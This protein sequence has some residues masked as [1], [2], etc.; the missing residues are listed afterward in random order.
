VNLEIEL[1]LVLV[2]AL[3]WVDL[4]IILRTLSNK[5]ELALSAERRR[6]ELVE[7]SR[8]FDVNTD[9]DKKKVKRLF[10]NY[11]TLKQSIDL[12]EPERQRILKSAKS[13]RKEPG[14]ARRIKFKNRYIRMD[15]SLDLALIASDTAR[16]T[17][18]AALLREK[19]FPVKLF[20]ANALADIMDPRSLPA[21]AESLLGAHRWYRDKVNML[22][23][24]YGLL[25]SEYLISI[26]DREENEIVE[27]LIDVAGLCVC[28]HLKS[29]LIR[30]LESGG[31][32][33]D[34]I[35]SAVRNAPD[36]SCAYCVHG[37][38]ITEDFKRDC[39]YQGKVDPGFKCRRWKL[40]VT[41]L[42]PAGNH[43][44]LMVKAA[45]NCAK[46]YAPS[47]HVPE[48]LDNPDKDIRSIAVKSLGQ[49]NSERHVKGL[50]HYLDIEET[51]LAAKLGLSQIL[52]THPRLS[53]LV[54]DVFEE[55]ENKR[56]KQA[57]SEILAG[58]IEYYIVKLATK[59]RESS[60]RLIRAVIQ[61]GKVSEIIE[62]LK[63]NKDVDLE[64][65]V[66]AIVKDETRAN[67]KLK[68]ECGLYLPESILS[69]I[70]L[71]KII[72]P[73]K[74]R[75]EARDG[76]M[77]AALYFILAFTL[78][79]FPF[80]YVIRYSD[81]V[82][83]V[84]IVQQLKTFVVDFNYDFAWY[85]M[86]VN[87]VYLILAMLSVLKVSSSTRLWNLKT[88][89]MM[90]KP[91]ML[92]SVSIIAPAFNEEKTIIESANS[93]MNLK[94]PDY[95]L[96]VVNDGSRDSTLDT[97]IQYFDLKRVD[98]YFVQRLKTAPVRGIYKNPLYPRLVVVD[99][100]NGG[101]ADSLN[102]GINIASR[103]YF[104]GIDADSLLEPDSL[105]KVASLTMD[106]GVETPAMGGNVF[107][108]NGCDVDKGK[109]MKVALPK[110]VL[111]RLQTVEYL[112]AFMCGRLGWAQVNSLLIISGAFGLFRRERVISIGGYLTS[113]EVFGRDTV[114]E[115]MEL[116][117]RVARLMREKKQ[118]YRIG[119]A[120]NANCWTEVP[121]SMKI[122][123]RQRDRWHRGLIDIMYFH[124][125]VLFNP[126]YG[127]MG[128][129]GMPYF[130]IF[131]MVGPL[132]EIQGYIMVAL[133][134]IFGLISTKLALLL[135][136]STIL[137]GILISVS[138]VLIAERQLYYFNTRDTL[139][140]FF[141]ALLENF[142]P[143]QVFSMWRVLG[144]FNA[145]KK[146]QG[147]GKM[148]RKGFAP[149]PTG[150]VHARS[151]AQGNSGPA[152]GGKKR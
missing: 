1:I 106:Y 8:L 119:Y 64:N 76:K 107:P 110:H 45:E 69:K 79:L 20:I 84:P 27:M 118:K 127:R 91:R 93:L 98:Y 146:P 87:A 19:D 43:H 142:G 38:K 101:K 115:D 5:S 100:E 9:W 41:N 68:I 94:Y 70:G 129:I 71:P 96:V 85:S 102:A 89:S 75:E 125:K 73:Q 123:K 53:P 136:V 147:W 95:E 33:L 62:F 44:R 10:S 103:E 114:G 148:E 66:A 126:S 81:R 131:E 58:R 40:L 42:N 137:M 54:V 56:L 145:L 32:T 88:M 134:A 144:F 130:L 67:E 6:K 77:I 72:P 49:G 34:R 140:M 152:G 97:I 59:E 7:L 116:V 35:S 36:K 63:L 57:L 92:P 13:E 132:F 99:K 112:R 83:Y 151:V 50:I 28:S 39:Q 122:L 113:K 109:L 18:E 37:R 11:L 47:L 12:P 23:A 139:K 149:K 104:C 3:L 150:A 17:L 26:F 48:Y 121:E 4:V 31:Q 74:K 111:A 105:L 65:A 80:L 138:A 25:A 29:Y 117:V 16:Q 55:S 128:M 124:R 108:I 15:A 90:F 133:A 143:R 135:F 22:I 14:L 51:M 86:A 78:S 61:Q 82:R 52:Q 30:I 141:L 24:S 120:Y 2:L 46:H 21:L 60:E